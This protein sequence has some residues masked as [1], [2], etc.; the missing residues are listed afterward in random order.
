LA[1]HPEVGVRIIIRRGDEILLDRR[2]GVHGEGTWS[3]CG[4]HLE[5]G[6]SFED[7]AIRETREETTL[8]VADPVFRGITNDIFESGE[9]H[10]ITVWME[11]R[12][13]SG[14]ASM[15]APYEMSALECHR[16]DALPEP[17]FLPFKLLLQGPVYPEGAA[18][19]LDVPAD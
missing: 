14:E 19:L 3:P 17:L 18:A 11:V 7:C 9:K 6:E 16:L 12:V 2:Q 8:E 10:T 4:G 5:F 15:N 1:Q 13:V